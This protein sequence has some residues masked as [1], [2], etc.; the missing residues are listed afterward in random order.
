[1]TLNKKE[2]LAL[3]GFASVGFK[4]KSSHEVVIAR[5]DRKFGGIVPLD[6]ALMQKKESRRRGAFSE[7]LQDRMPAR[8]CILSTLDNAFRAAIITDAPHTARA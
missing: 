7:A 4:A 3:A 6:R 1:M 2:I 8:A 5:V